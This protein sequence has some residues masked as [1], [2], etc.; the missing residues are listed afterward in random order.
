MPRTSQLPIDDTEWQLLAGLM[1]NPCALDEI[2]SRLRAEDFGKDA[3]QRLYRAILALRAAD[4]PLQ[5]VTLTEMLM[6]NGELADV[7]GYGTIGELEL[8]NRTAG[9]VFLCADL[10]V[11][12]ARNR[13]L[14]DILIRR[15]QD[16]E[17]T[18]TDPGIA[19]EIAEEIFVQLRDQDQSGTQLMPELL[20]QVEDAIDA[21]CC[22]G[23]G[24]TMVQTG[25]VDVDH[26]TGGLRPG[27]LVILAGRPGTGKTALAG[28]IARNV[29]K[30]GLAVWMASLEQAGREIVERILTAEACVDHENVRDGRLSPEQVGTL[31][32][33]IDKMRSWNFAINSDPI[34]KIPGITA[35]VRRFLVKQQVKLVIVDYTQLVQEES[36]N[37]RRRQRHEI[38]GDIAKGLKLLARTL[39]V[40]VL[41]LSQLNREIENR[42]FGKP[43]LSDIR[44]SDA[45]G[46][47]ADLVMVLVKDEEAGDVI[48]I[49]VLK[50]RNG[51]EGQ[52]ALY[53][54][55]PQLRFENYSPGE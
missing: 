14:R 32:L 51:Q 15:V 8:I 55:R 11:R 2:A 47:H 5:L 26:L 53:F 19:S 45:I 12:H 9:N 27:E 30:R 52:S 22:G 46:A 25:Y 54:R 7:G 42:A 16:L 21:R 31:K 33:T 41:A 34:Q 4:K 37:N 24:A 39:N 50:N 23:A 20:G 40:P 10:V 44:E 6:A 38:V 3:H 29:L 49:Y 18:P 17:N 48:D 36:A 43:R 1:H 28:N 13:R 35:E